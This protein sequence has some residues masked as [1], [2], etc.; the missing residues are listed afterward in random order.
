[1]LRRPSLPLRR[2]LFEL[3]KAFQCLPGGHVVRVQRVQPVAQRVFCRLL[4]QGQLVQAFAIAGV[5]LPLQPFQLVPGGLDHLSR[6]AGQGGHLQA[7]ALVRRA[8]L[9]RVQED[10]ASP[11]SIASRCT[12]AMVVELLGQG[13]QL[14]VVSGEQA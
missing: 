12:L 14:E 8:I 4:E 7:V 6:D 2:Q 11:C 1:M 5:G 9:H 13:G 3:I 10:D